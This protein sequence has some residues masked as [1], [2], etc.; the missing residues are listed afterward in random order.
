M[1]YAHHS[2]AHRPRERT[3]LR[4]CMLRRRLV[5]AQVEAPSSLFCRAFLD[6]LPCVAGSNSHAVNEKA[7]QV[8]VPFLST[9]G[10]REAVTCGQR[11]RRFVRLARAMAA[12]DIQSVNV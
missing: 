12:L 9:I 2:L 10:R 1:G 4:A 11:V 8:V 5:R 7:Q 6:S 3:Q